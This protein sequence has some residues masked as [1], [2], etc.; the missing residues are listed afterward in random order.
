MNTEYSAFVRIHLLGDIATHPPV[1]PVAR[2]PLSR[3]VALR[4]PHAQT[5][6]RARPTAVS[7]LK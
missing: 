1:R 7:R 4:Q 2:L 5:H 3:L 6:H